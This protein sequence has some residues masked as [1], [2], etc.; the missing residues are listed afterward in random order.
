MIREPVFN[1]HEIH[2]EPVITREMRKGPVKAKGMK[3]LGRPLAETTGLA[4]DLDH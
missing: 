2:C 3:A 4:I 1:L